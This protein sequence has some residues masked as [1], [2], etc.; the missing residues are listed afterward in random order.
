MCG[1]HDLESHIY[2]HICAHK[3]TKFTTDFYN[4]ILKAFR[5][6]LEP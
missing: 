4:D 5:N 1:I 3:Y 2:K 6:S